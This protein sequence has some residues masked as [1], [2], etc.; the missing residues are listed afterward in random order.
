MDEKISFSSYLKETR[1]DKKMTLKELAKKS[2]TSDSYLSQLE[3]NRR[4]PPKPQ[5]LKSIAKALSKGDN[6][7]AALIYGRLSV[8][9][10][11]DLENGESGEYLYELAKDTFNDEVLKNVATIMSKDMKAVAYVKLFTDFYINNDSE[12]NSKNIAFLT[13]IMSGLETISSSKDQSKIE[14]T[15][16]NITTY[17]DLLVSSLID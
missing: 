13:S 12:N 3:N 17:F 11:Y 9:A 6:K 4:N 8:L 10:G 2:D 14:L 7:E 15:K 16:E 5:L 1:Q